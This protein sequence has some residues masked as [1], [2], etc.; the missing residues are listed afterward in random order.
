MFQ[1]ITYCP[2]VS[3]GP[4]WLSVP[5]A[6]YFH[7]EHRAASSLTILACNFSQIS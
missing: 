7:D 2:T 1:L 3:E 5:G 6:L 4:E